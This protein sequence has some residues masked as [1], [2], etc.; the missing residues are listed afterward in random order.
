MYVELCSTQDLCKGLIRVKIPTCPLTYLGALS[1]FTYAY[2]HMR[3]FSTKLGW[4]QPLW[5]KRT[6]SIVR[7]TSKPGGKYHENKLL[8]LKSNCA[9]NEL[10]IINNCQIPKNF[11]SNFNSLKKVKKLYTPWRV[12]DRTTES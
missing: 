10:K 2:Q 6:W 11:H 7:R 3:M 12:R 9:D 1:Q 4:D 5:L 8:T